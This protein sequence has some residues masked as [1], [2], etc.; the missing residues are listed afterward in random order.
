M[1]AL[2]RVLA[3]LRRSGP[4]GTD[5]TP[6]GLAPRLAMLGAAAPAIE[7]VVPE[8]LVVFLTSS[9]LA[10]REV[11]AALAE[12]P[13]VLG[14]VQAVTPDPT[15]EDARAVA[16]LT[17]PGVRVVMSTAAWG[18]YGASGAPWVA[19]VTGGIV[20]A[21]GPAAGWPDVVALAARPRR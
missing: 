14:P 18:A 15:L 13:S 2:T 5:S 10:C 7:G 3:R 17:P 11:W 20:T 8:G 1:A 6:G 19:V 9:C 21:E 4:G 16:A 12:G